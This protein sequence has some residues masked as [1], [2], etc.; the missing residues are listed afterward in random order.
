M[1]D[2]SEGRNLYLKNLPGGK[3][4]QRAGQRYGLGLALV[5]R[6]VEAHGGRIG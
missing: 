3:S 6:I 4:R 5:K 1:R 2:P